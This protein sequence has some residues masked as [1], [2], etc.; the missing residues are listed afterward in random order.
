MGD[1]CKS[2][3]SNDSINDSAIGFRYIDAKAGDLVVTERD[4]NRIQVFDF[5]GGETSFDTHGKLGHGM[6]D[7]FHPAGVCTSNVYGA[8]VIVADSGNKR[9]KYMKYNQ[10][11]KGMGIL[12]TTATFGQQTFTEPMGIQHD[13][14]RNVVIVTDI[15]SNRVTIHDMRTGN[16]IG[17]VKQPWNLKLQRPMDVAIDELSRMYVTDAVGKCVHIYDKNGEFICHFGKDL[18]VHPWGVTFDRQYNVLVSDT[19]AN[20]IYMFTT[21]GALQKVAIDNIYRPKGIA[22]NINEK[23]VATTGDPYN[24]L[25][26]FDFK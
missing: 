4:N 2:T 22:V 19:E 11:Q 18:F 10:D 17:E 14:Y 15:G 20:K 8:N 16:P 9:M 7:Y 3:I 6:Q 25:K 24:F 21:T 5:Q 13:P 12:D 1:K 26:I 23:L